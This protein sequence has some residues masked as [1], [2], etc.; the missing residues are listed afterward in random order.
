M[1]YNDVDKKHKKS[2]KHF[3]AVARGEQIG[4]FTS[5]SLC[6]Q[7]VNKYQGQ[8]FKGFNTIDEAMHFMNPFSYTC[9]N[10][11]IFD[12]L[13]ERKQAKDYNHS[14]PLCLLSENMSTYVD[15]D[16]S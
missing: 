15:S 10:V 13:G 6:E 7:S 11:P 16:N 9:Q 5:W 4:I 14:C 2:R 12:D 3:Y 8:L 1:A